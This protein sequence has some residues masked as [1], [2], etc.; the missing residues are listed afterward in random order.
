[1]EFGI[2]TLVVD[3]SS[4]LAVDFAPMLEDVTFTPAAKEVVEGGTSLS[5]GGNPGVVVANIVAIFIP[6]GGVMLGLIV[7]D[8]PLVLAV[9]TTLDIVGGAPTLVVVY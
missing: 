4:T 5:L 2:G 8:K 9:V 1:M 6:G 3:L 7:V